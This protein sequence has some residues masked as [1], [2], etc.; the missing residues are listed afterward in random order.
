MTFYEDKEREIVLFSYEKPEF[1]NELGF[2]KIVLKDCFKK[3]TLTENVL[4]KKIIKVAFK[5][6][7]TIDKV[8]LDLRMGVVLKTIEETAWMK[9]EKD[10]AERAFHTKVLESY[11]AFAKEMKLPSPQISDNDSEFEPL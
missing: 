10:K 1:V 8:D 3:Y 4:N 11:R 7:G 6:E 9:I 5:G 2:E